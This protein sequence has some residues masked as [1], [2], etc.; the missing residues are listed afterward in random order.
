M[1]KEPDQ[2][3]RKAITEEQQNKL[4][5]LFYLLKKLKISF[6]SEM[7]FA[8][9]KTPASKPELDKWAFIFASSKKLPF[10]LDELRALI[11]MVEA[12][13]EGLPLKL[14]AKT[15]KYENR[16]CFAITFEITEKLEESKLP[17]AKEIGQALAEKIKH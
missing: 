10:G 2:K 1:E 13:I 5:L 4:L 12:Q 15:V 11:E 7:F 6:K 8:L 9:I 3:Q 14:E 16:K 17:N